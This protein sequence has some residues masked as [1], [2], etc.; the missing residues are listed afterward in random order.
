[1]GALVDTSQLDKAKAEELIAAIPLMPELES[2]DV[3][4]YT[5]NTG[6]PA[7]RLIFRVRRDVKIDEI[8]IDRFIQFSAIVQTRILHSNLNRFPYTRLEQA[9]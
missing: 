3:E 8:F 7:F 4:L 5:D 6:D 1:M 9:A 2:I